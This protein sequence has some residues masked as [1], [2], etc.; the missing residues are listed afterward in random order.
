VAAAGAVLI[1]VGAVLFVVT[2][3][4][5]VVLVTPADEK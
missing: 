4:R 2:R 3:R 1:A 5:R